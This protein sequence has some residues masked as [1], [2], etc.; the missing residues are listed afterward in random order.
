MNYDKIHDKP[1]HFTLK[2]RDPKNEDVPEVV[3][4]EDKNLYFLPEEMLELRQ[5]Y[6]EFGRDVP[7]ECLEDFAPD[8]YDE[9]WWAMLDFL[10]G[11]MSIDTQV[12][13]AAAY[14]NPVMN[15]DALVLRLSQELPYNLDDYYIV[16]PK[17]LID[18]VLDDNFTDWVGLMNELDLSNALADAEDELDEDWDDDK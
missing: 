5:F 8:S 14:P 1:Y 16:P 13:E 9:D 18:D 12:A 15:R 17:E 2:R 7:F 4:S 3:I 6:K 11:S 10:Y